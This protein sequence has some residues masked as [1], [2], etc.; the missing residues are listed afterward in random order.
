MFEVLTA[1]KMSLQ[2]F[3]LAVQY[4][5]R[6]LHQS[7]RNFES[8]DFHL[9]GITS[10]FVASKVQDVVPLYMRTILTKIGHGRL[11]QHEILDMEKQILQGLKFRLTGCPTSL[12]F[13]EIFLQNPY[14]KNHKHHKFIR[15]FSTYL[16]LL[17]LHH[18]QFCTR[19]SSIIAASCILVALGVL[20]KLPKK[21]K[22]CDSSRKK[23]VEKNECK[24]A[25]QELITMAGCLH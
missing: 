2:T 20:D 4:L 1:F 3:Y 7:T 11:K 9:I 24:Q 10:M 18:I 22:N 16:S 15:D 17:C 5:D 14:F 8:K 23:E 25:R 13:I 6:L 19:D 21:E 12:E